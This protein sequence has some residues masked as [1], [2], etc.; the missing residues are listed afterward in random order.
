MATISSDGSTPGPFQA[1]PALVK[2]NT[3]SGNNSPT[4]GTGA[5]LGCIGLSTLDPAPQRS[6]KMPNRRTVQLPDQETPADPVNTSENIVEETVN[7]ASGRYEKHL[8]SGINTAKVSKG[9]DVE[10]K[11]GEN[12]QQPSARDAIRHETL[13]GAVADHRDP[14]RGGNQTVCTAAVVACNSKMAN[15]VEAPVECHSCE[16]HCWYACPCSCHKLSD[17]RRIKFA[18]SD[19]EREAS[20]VHATGAHVAVEKSG[21]SPTSSDA[22]AHKGEMATTRATRRDRVRKNSN[23]IGHKKR[24]H[25]DRLPIKAPDLRRAFLATSEGREATTIRFGTAPRLDPTFLG[26]SS[27]AGVGS[28]GRV[29][30]YDVW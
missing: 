25:E 28:G 29:Y 4:N 5:I 17:R 11:D 19:G 7:A 1:F 12:K 16:L 27:T 23:D 13:I 2:S 10:H 3:K 30:F 18:I 21:T 20:D 9:F 14:E 8:G 22:V 26:Q 6:V 24:H 15:T